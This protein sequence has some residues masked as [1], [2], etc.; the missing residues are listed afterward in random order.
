MRLARYAA[1]SAICLLVVTQPVPVATA[2]AQPAVPLYRQFLSAPSPLDVVAAKKVDRVA[3]IAFEEGKR[4]AYTAVPPAFTPVRLT[5]FLKDDGIDMSDIQIS[6]DGSTVVFVRGTAPNREG[7]VANPTADPNGPERSIWAARTSGGV[8]WRV[9]EGASPE[10]AP[11]GSSVLFVKD[12]QIYRAKLTPVRQP[13]EMDRGEKAFITE[14]GVQSA[15]QW[16][17]D[18]KK[19]AFVTTRTDHSFIA[20]YD[21]A[22]RSVKYLSPSVDFDASPLWSADGRTIVFVRRPGLPF[23]QQA[24]QGTGG[25]GLANGPAFQA[26]QGRGGRGQAAPQASPIPPA[27]QQIAGLTRATFKGGYTLSLWKADVATGEAEEVWHNEPND[28]LF[29]AFTNLRLAGDYVVFPLAAFGGRGGRG[30]GD[31][32]GAPPSP[33]PAGDR[34]TSGIATTRSTSRPRIEPVLLTTT[35]GLIEDQTSVAISADSKTF[36]YC[37]NAK[38]IERRHIWAVPVGGR[39][40]VADHDRRRRRDVARAAGVRQVRWRR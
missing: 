12:G 19:I 20:V 16:S 6:D 18:G 21:L 29:S 17:P 36:F 11:D 24:Q 13:R 10:L 38:D 31:Q 40:A 1:I 8:A 22:T 3:F 32:T 23:G 37:T 27:A 34:R 39:D 14:W 25:L 9:A 35:D 26:A 7:W 30:R 33:P 4:N 28:R 2:P 5:S 15:P